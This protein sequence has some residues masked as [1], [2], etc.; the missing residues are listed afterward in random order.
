GGFVGAVSVGL[1]LL[2][3]ATGVSV[4]RRL[5]FL[6]VAI[7][8]L[9][10]AAPAGYWKQMQTVLNPTNDYNWKSQGGRKQLWTRVMSYMWAYPVFGV[11]MGN[12]GRAEGTISERARKHTINQ[13]GIR[14]AAPHNTFVQAAAEMGVTGLIVFCWL[15]IGGTAAMVR[16][17]RRIPKEWARGSPQQRFLSLAP[18]YL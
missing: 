9:S 14:W 15:V 16:L 1:A 6:A 11:G 12:F 17:R 13:P 5:A 4:P 2:L 3:G 18:M 10:L 7:I 8:G